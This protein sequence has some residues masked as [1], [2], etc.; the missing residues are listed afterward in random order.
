MHLFEKEEK[1][2]MKILIIKTGAFGDMII[3]ST[4]FQTIRENFPDSKIYLLTSLT[5]KDIVLPCSIFEK[6]FFL[7]PRYQFFKFLKLFY[8]LRKEKF[9]IIFDIQGNLMTNFYCF[10]LKGKKKY[11]FY[12][13][14]LGRLFLTEGIKKGKV[15]NPV[16]GLFEIFKF[17]E[18]KKIIKKMRVWIPDEKRVKFENFIKKYGLDKEKKWIL[19]H[20]LSSKGHLTKR[21]DKENFALLSDK[22]IDDGF[23]IIFI[24]SGEEEYINDIIK[25]MKNKPINL[26][27]KTDFYNLS[28]LLEKALLLIT[29]DSGPL[30]LGV[31]SGT[32]VLGIFGPTDPKKHCP[33]DVFI[34]YKKV[35]CSP[36]YKKRCEVMK[37]MKEIKVEEVYE[38]AKEIIK[39]E[40]CLNNNTKF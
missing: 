28:L 27:N 35:E 1:F 15:I 6:I 23:D 25:K 21:W 24:G 16:E 13:R 18:V 31:A 3:A 30:H 22:F 14:K 33:P 38:R 26:V 2:E 4:F 5:Y 34:I 9:D 40:I 10:L 20:P 17:L 19:I 29:G 37:C 8:K 12:R 11:G 39:N 7:P 32:R 36:C